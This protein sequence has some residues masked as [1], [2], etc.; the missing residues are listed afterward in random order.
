MTPE[1]NIPMQ[2]P[3]RW[4]A[5]RP[6]EVRKAGKHGALIAAG[7]AATE[8]SCKHQVRV[9]MC[10]KMMTAYRAL[11]PQWPFYVLENEVFGDPPMLVYVLNDRA[12]DAHLYTNIHTYIHTDRQTGRQAGRQTDRQAGRQTDR[13]T[14][15]YI[16][17][18]T[19]THLCLH[20]QMYVCISIYSY[21]RFVLCM[22]Y[23]FYLHASYRGARTLFCNT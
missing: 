1:R 13:Q 14:N 7:A 15:I 9:A 10:V 23:V 16:Y 22:L 11:A 6:H 5:A 18:H 21:M 4:T 17:T 3:G 2:H 20:I 12:F 8:R 19:H